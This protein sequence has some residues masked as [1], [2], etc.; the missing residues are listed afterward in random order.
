MVVKMLLKIPMMTTMDLLTTLMPVLWMQEQVRSVQ[1]SVAATTIQMGTATPLMCSQQIRH[2]GWMQMAMDMATPRWFR[3]RWMRQSSRAVNDGFLRMSGCG[4]RWLVRFERCFPNEASQHA[5]A[6]SDGFGDAI[7]G[8]QADECPMIAG[9]S[10]ED[11][12]GCLDSD[13]DGWSDLNDAFPQEPTQHS[14]ADGDGYGDNAEGDLP[15]SCPEL[16]GL[17]SIDRYGCPDTDGDGWEDRS[18]AYVSDVRLWS[19]IDDDGYADQQGT[20]LSDDCPETFGTSI[21]DFVG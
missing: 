11:F 12:F 3:S 10:T 5:D 2:S 8:F 7:D 20:N 6:D 16:Y 21:L 4:W 19:D 18:D 13:A 14:D 15:D 17:S 1:N 9:T